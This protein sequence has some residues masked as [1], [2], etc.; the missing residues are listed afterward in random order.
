MK[1]RFKLMT[2][3]IEE[4]CTF[5]REFENEDEAIQVAQA[6]S[7]RRFYPHHVIQ[8]FK[9]KKTG[10]KWELVVWDTDRPQIMDYISFY[11][12]K[13]AIFAAKLIKEYDKTLKTNIN[14]IY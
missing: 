8:I 3:N 9:L 14:K 11:S 4:E 2:W 6:L 5:S 13:E 1:T 12:K 10:H 7:R